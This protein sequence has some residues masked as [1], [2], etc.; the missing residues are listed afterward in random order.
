MFNFALK[1]S[2]RIKTEKN[3]D[4]KIIYCLPFLSIIDQN[5]KVLNEVLKNPPSNILL[6]HHH[7]LSFE[8]F[9]IND[10]RTYQHLPLS[11]Y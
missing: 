5:Y 8:V 4:M 9:Y 1:L 11:L 7:L 6:K 10:I 3:I 2:N